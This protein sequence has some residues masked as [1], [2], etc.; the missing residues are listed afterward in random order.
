EEGCA[1]TS[2]GALETRIM[3]ESVG[4]LGLACVTVF[5]SFSIDD[6]E[7]GIESVVS[8]TA[9]CAVARPPIISRTV[10][11][12]VS[13]AG[14]M[15]IALPSTWTDKCRSQKGANARRKLLLKSPNRL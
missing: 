11:S 5:A 4:S 6:V 7:G 1:R 15:Y 2:I 12:T 9:S 8:P 3:P 13:V 10:T 14:L